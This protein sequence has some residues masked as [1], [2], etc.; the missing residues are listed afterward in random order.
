MEL[1]NLF[2]PHCKHNPLPTTPY[3]RVKDILETIC[4]KGC[5]MYIWQLHWWLFFSPQKSN[6]QGHKDKLQTKSFE[7]WHWKNL[8]THNK[9]IYWNSININRWNNNRKKSRCSLVHFFGVTYRE[10]TFPEVAPELT[11]DYLVPKSS[12][13]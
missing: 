10:L 7:K 9:N 8:R 5:F 1:Q 13:H 2:L 11:R 3:T 6:L 12:M 4:N